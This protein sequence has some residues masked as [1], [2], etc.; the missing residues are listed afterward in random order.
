MF[1][2]PN[3]TL[4][5]ADIFDW[6]ARR[7]VESGEEV[8]Q[9]HWQGQDVSDLLTM[10]PLELRNVIFTMPIY[11]RPSDAAQYIR[12]NLPWAE[13]HFQERVGGKPLNPPPSSAIWPHRTNDHAA[14]V[15]Q[16]KKFSHTYPE[17]FWPKHAGPAH[18]PTQCAQDRAEGFTYCDLGRNRGVRYE[19]GDLRDVLNLL[20]HDQPTR[21][22][23]LPVWFPEDTGAVE[24]QRVPCTLGYHFMI[25]N[26]RLHMTYMIR[27]CDLL[28]HFRDDVYMAIRLG[29]WMASRAGEL[30]FGNLT[31][32]VM[33]MHVF[34][35][36]HP[37]MKQLIEEIPANQSR[38]LMERM[39]LCM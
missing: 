8:P 35:G 24:G 14:F 17:R 3:W 26:N 7:L 31:M 9:K 15:D 5:F 11:A 33:S 39:A 32:H 1:V 13:D 22:A 2:L 4:D 34:A 29:Q 6:V 18:G 25:R 16:G 21:Q 10:Q 37:M 27:A 38:R 30:D 12:P 20:R 36:D 23:Y 19:Y 28:R